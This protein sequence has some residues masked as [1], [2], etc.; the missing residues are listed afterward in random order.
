MLLNSNE[1]PGGNAEAAFRAQH[2]ILQKQVPLMYVLMLIN[3]TFVSIAAHESLPA[4]LSIGVPAA[5]VLVTAVRA[6]IWLSRDQATLPLSVIRRQLRGTLVAAATLSALFGAW[7]L[8]LFSEADPAR[9]TAVALYVFVGSISCSYCLH[10]LPGAARLVLLFGAMP[11]T[12]RLLVSGDWYLAGI[13]LTFI[14]VAGLILHTLAAGRASFLEL[15]RSKSEMSALLEA[16]QQSEEHHRYSVELNPQIPWTSD[17]DGSIVELSPRWSVETGIALMDGLGAG[18]QSSVHPEDLPGLL[19]TWQVARAPGDRIELDA[20][21][22][23]R[24]QDGSYRW[25]RAR[26]YPRYDPGGHIVKWYGNLE[27]IHEQ[28]TAELALRE[29]EERYRLAARATNDII[30]DW[31]HVTD[32]IQWAD[33]HE[34][35]FGYPASEGATGKWWIERVHPEDL[36]V[37]QALYSHVMDGGEE[38]WSH[39]YRFRAADGSYVVVL[40][41]GYVIRDGAGNALRSIGAMVDVTVE[42]RIEENLRWAAYHDSLTNLPNRKMF[43]EQ[44]D[45][46]LIKGAEARSCVGV[47]VLDV[48]GFKSINDNLGHAAG[49]AVLKKVAARLQANLP[50]G[51]IAARLGGDEFAIILT[52]LVRED[53]CEATVSRIIDGVGRGLVIEQSVI[54]VS[55]SAGAAMWPIDGVTS[56]DVMKSAD[57]ALYTAKAEGSSAIRGFVPAMRDRIDNRNRMLSDAREALRDDR[58][59][60]FY[61]PKI[62]LKSGEVAGFEALL[63]WHH[64]RQGL[65]PPGTLKAAFEDS[66]LSTQLTDRMI[67]RVVSD[68]MLWLQQGINFGRVAINGSSADFRG[69]NFADRILGRFSEAGL[70]PSLL[71]LEI[72]ETVFLGQHADSVETTLHTLAGAGVTIALDDFGT[73]FASLTHLQQFPVDVLKIDRSFISRLDGKRSADIAIVQGVIDIARRMGIQT[74]AEGV[75]NEAQLACLRELGCDIAQGYLF[76]RAMAA[77]R[78]SSFSEKWDV[79]AARDR[80]RPAGGETAADRFTNN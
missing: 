10:A 52:G 48:D 21:Y 8:L 57:L 30:W 75:E 54:D 31:S 42:R 16:L 11:I 41:R 56:E 68:M 47:I 76:S 39:E 40:S 32:E 25:F 79:N 22:R 61:Q 2:T 72:T 58:I 20:R 5:L 29:S 51:G 63:R 59:V 15:L 45:E 46:A 60:P 67:N 9:A 28:V 71:E 74:V 53:A 24:K 27:D 78:I 34:S 38:G 17:P 43:S 70:S 65:H 49:D 4:F 64:H 80:T 18:W 69:G 55:L 36:S 50:V 6:V 14:L 66:V 35:I 23:L 77:S 73:G 33:G 19:A 7:G 3:V 62:A 1:S 26:A 37:A 44:L 13:G 12:A